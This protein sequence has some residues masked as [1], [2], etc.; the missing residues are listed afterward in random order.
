MASESPGVTAWKEQTSAFDRV[1]SIATGLDRPR[2][3]PYIASEAAVAENTARNHLGRLVEMNVLLATDDNGTTLYEPDP[4]HTRLRTL[5]SLLAS[6]SHD[7][8]LDLKA[9]L[10]AQIETWQAEYDAATPAALRQSAADSETPAET[11]AIRSTA[12]EWALTAYRLGIVADA[13]ENY[14]TYTSDLPASA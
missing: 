3:A 1:H 7:E 12:N 5:R 9:D 8:L 2:P 11:R 10:Q 6:H 4:L 14:A 13:I